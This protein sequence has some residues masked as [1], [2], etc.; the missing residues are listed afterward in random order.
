MR[1]TLGRGA[2]AL[3]GL[4][5]ILSGAGTGCSGR[6]VPVN[7]A[8]EEI[9]AAA[10]RKLDEEDWYDAAEL[11]ELFLRNHPG[12]AQA[13]LAKIRL[14]DARFGLEE[15]LVARAH[16]EDVVQDF[17][18]SSWV[19]EAR[20]GIARCSYASVRPWDRDPTETERALGLLEEF[21]VDHP[22][23]RFLPEVEAAIADCRDRLAHREFEAGRFYAKQRRPRSAK[24]QFQYVLDNFPETPWAPKA[25]YEIGEI[26][27]VRGKIAEAERYLR[28]V[29]M[30]WPDTE[31]SKR[32][33]ASLSTL[34]IARV[35]APEDP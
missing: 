32:A 2:M 17:P 16:Y 35:E 29:V 22:S 11:F 30:D 4:A 27:R 19:E 15:Y 8:P 23:S 10:Q 34:G 31:E 5:F 1:R 18:A 33:A 28:R 14:G 24:T 13:P 21:R 6:S 12:S 25:C 26:Y 7:A 9:L 3:L 20:W